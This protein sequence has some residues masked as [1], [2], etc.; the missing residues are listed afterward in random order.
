MENSLKRIPFALAMGVVKYPL[1]IT[2][3]LIVIFLQRSC[4]EPATQET[5]KT[6]VTIP[7][8]KGEIKKFVEQINYKK[9]D[10]IVFV[11]GKVIYTENEIDKDLAEKYKKSVDSLEKFKMYINA[12]QIKEHTTIFDNKDLTLKVKS[13]VRGDLLNMT[14]T[15]Y[16]T[17][18]QKVVV[19]VP[20]K[21]RTAVY[22]GLGVSDN[23]RLDNFTV[24]AEVGL[25]IKR[26]ILS[27][28]ADTKQ[29]FGLKYLIKL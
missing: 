22:V 19:E 8:K 16:K 20:I 13:K 23:K 2:L 24:Q 9:K 26:D 14:I 12:V 10:S 15:E 21:T 6:E 1:I 4:S 18:E 27:I 29:N 25:Q 28:T 11:K 17:K 7:E 5:I 3:L